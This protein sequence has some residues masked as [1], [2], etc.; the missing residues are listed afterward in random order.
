MFDSRLGGAIDDK[1][2]WEGE[3][4][5][6]QF[7]RRGGFNASG[8]K[9]SKR[10]LIFSGGASSTGEEEEKLS[11]EE[12]GPLGDYTLGM[13]IFVKDLMGKTIA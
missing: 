4:V 13:Q 7:G 5:V 3:R 6:F 2:P 11:E 9:F 10:G 12:K 8:R 1:Y